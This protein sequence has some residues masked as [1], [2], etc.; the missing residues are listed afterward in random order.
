VLADAPDTIHYDGA[1]L[2]Y[3]G[4]LLL[5]NWYRPREGATLPDRPMGAAVGLCFLVRR[6]AFQAVGGFFEPMFFFFEDND[7]ALRLRLRGFALRLAPDAVV[8]HRGGTSGLSMR[9]G[10][11]RLPERRTYLHSRN[12]WLLLLACLHWRTL[13]LTLPAQLA[14]AFVHLGFAL[15]QGHLRAWLAGKRDLL[16]MLPAT[17]TRRGA[18]Q[19]TRVRADR[20]L[21]T[22]APFTFNPQV[23]N[24]PPGRVARRVLDALFIGYWRCVRWACG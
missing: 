16:R 3:L 13:L 1:D 18:V 4:M 14:Y 12:R 20:D 2:H 7:F 17:W 19:R 21:L 6:E 23:A 8:L 15:R 9:G 11:A 22:A 10:E 5:H 24:G